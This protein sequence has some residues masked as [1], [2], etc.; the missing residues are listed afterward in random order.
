MNANTF[1]SWSTSKSANGT[2]SFSVTKNTST[3]E[4][5]ANGRYCITELAKAQDGFK[6]RA[7]AKGQA[8]KWLR[9]LR[10]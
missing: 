10:A 7:R 2:F 8:V 3:T 5:L 4:A 1:Y 6:T 9:Y